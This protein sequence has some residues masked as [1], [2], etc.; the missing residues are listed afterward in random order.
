MNVG[1]YVDKE[2]EIKD[3]V[4]RF[5]QAEERMVAELEQ[6]RAQQQLYESLIAEKGKKEQEIREKREL[7]EKV[8]P[9]QAKKI[10]EQIH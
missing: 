9:A 6:R 1:E 3:W 4:D 10:L 2:V 5:E 7:Y 8:L